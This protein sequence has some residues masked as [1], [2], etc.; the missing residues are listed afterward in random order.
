MVNFHNSGS[1]IAVNGTKDNSAFVY[2]HTYSDISNLQLTLYT[3]SF[4]THLQIRSNMYVHIHHFQLPYKA[5]VE[6]NTI[7]ENGE[8]MDCILNRVQATGSYYNI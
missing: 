2:T 7:H 5:K 4:T 3:C 6:Y 8:H 1:S